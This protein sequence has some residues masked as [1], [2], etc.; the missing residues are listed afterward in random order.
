MSMARLHALW[1]LVLF[2]GDAAGHPKLNDEKPT[3]CKGDR[4]LLSAAIGT[5]D[6]V[7]DT[8]CHPKVHGVPWFVSIEDHNTLARKAHSR[9]PRSNEPR[10]ERSA[11]VF[12]FRQ[13]RH[14]GR[15]PRGC[16]PILATSQ[17]RVFRRSLYV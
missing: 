14:C 10:I 6:R 11:K 2:D 9:K 1:R 12:D 16:N 15:V 17:R 7:A 8:K 13:F 5:D 4:H 3:A